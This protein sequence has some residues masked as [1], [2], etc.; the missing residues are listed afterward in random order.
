M[1]VDVR[2]TEIGYHHLEWGARALR[3]E[4]SIDARL[5]AVGGRHCVTVHFQNV[6][7]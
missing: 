5:F 7:E 6:P 2:H 1:P 4:E 3:G